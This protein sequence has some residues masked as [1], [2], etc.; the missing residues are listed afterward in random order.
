MMSYRHQVRI[1]SDVLLA[2][3]DGHEDGVGVAQ[4]MRKAN[5]SYT[6]LIK[7]LNE[8]TSVGLVEEIRDERSRRYR[9]TYLGLE[10]LAEYE[11]FSTFVRTFGLEI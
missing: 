1:V 9:I 5:I 3:K 7:I 4:L 10:Y 8:L 11:R 2:V 6:R